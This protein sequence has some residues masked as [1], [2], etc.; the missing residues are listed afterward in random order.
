MDE[1]T[2]TARGE[3]VVP[4]RPDEG[5][6]T[7]TL[8]ALEATPDGALGDVAKRSGTLDALLDELGVPR[9]KRSTTGL[10]V[11]EEFDYA[12]GKQTHRGFRAA[13][14]VTVRLDDP[15]IA[16]RL[17]RDAIDRTKANVRGPEWW[18]APDNPARLE[19]CRR[20]AVEAKRK[21][22][23]YA[24]ALGLGLGG[25]VEV[26]EPAPVGGAFPRAGVLRAAAEA[27]TLEVDPG[28][29]N[30]E[31]IVEIRFRLNE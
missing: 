30:V 27:S 8:S 23:A 28:Q 2:V 18:I 6:W 5:I 25:V 1:P 19:A 21:A 22:E 12:D 4:G 20:A 3:A 29:L 16:G 24:D 9:E 7:V 17:I 15:S 11:R 14:V 26:R 13:N 31:A 10:T